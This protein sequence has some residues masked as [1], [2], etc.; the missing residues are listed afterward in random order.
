MLYVRRVLQRLERG[1]LAI[2]EAGITL[3][4]AGGGFAS[5]LQ[6]RTACVP[7]RAPPTV[8]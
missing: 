6:S 7:C 1:E 2:G 5:R 8:V 4:K 3:L